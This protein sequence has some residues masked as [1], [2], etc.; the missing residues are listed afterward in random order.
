MTFMEGDVMINTVYNKQN[1]HLRKGF[2]LIELII[3]I[4][5][6]AI[7]VGVVSL[8]V[9]LIRSAD[10]K[11]LASHIND[12]L[13]DLKAI[14][15]AHTGPYYLHI[16]KDDGAYWKY[17]DSSSTFVK[18]AS[19]ASENRLGP[20]SMGVIINDS[21]GSRLLDDASSD[22]VT[23]SIKKKDGSYNTGVPVSMDVHRAS[24]G[25]GTADYRVIISEKT[26]LHYLEQL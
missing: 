8:S 25:S 26:G 19:N 9:G 15:E 3:A 5:I 18:P 11:G 24:D 6:L 20:D 4:A 23:V 7:F 1:D 22:S 16:Y 21:S 12:S 10:T 14:T 17:Y 13:T 2:S